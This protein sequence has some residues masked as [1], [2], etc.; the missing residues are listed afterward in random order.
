MTYGLSVTGPKSNGRALRS[1]FFGTILT[2]QRFHPQERILWRYLDQAASVRELLRTPSARSSE[3]SIKA[4]FGK[5][6]F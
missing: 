1:W 6:P 2:R 4:K 5:L 3:D